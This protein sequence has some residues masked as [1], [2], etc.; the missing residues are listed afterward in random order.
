MDTVMATR[1]LIPPSDLLSLFGTADAP[2]LLD[3][4]R[5]A[6]FEAAAYMLTDAQR[7]APQNVPDWA[8]A[9]AS[10]LS[11]TVVVYCVY[12]HQ[13][14]QG[15]CDILRA[16]GWKA[17]FLAGGIEGGEDGVDSPR[18]IASWRAVELPKTSKTSSTPRNAT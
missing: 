12:G 7:C 8:A 9:N 13:V 11:R 10:K 14:S 15:A 17:Y 6:A 1:S 2:L 16:L 3:V 5:D 4:R 18:D